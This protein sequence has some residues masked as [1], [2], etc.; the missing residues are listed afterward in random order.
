M[1]KSARASQIK[2]NRFNIRK[3]VFNKPDLARAERLSA[4]LMEVAAQPKPERPQ[5]MDVDVGVL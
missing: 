4:K 2:T 5:A 3:K 1:A